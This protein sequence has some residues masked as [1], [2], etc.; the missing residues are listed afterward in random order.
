MEDLDLDQ[1]EQLEESPFPLASERHPS[2]HL[3]GEF[4][5]DSLHEPLQQVSSLEE[6]AESSAAAESRGFAA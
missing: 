1:R 5:L 2:Y 3:V 6:L 4:Q